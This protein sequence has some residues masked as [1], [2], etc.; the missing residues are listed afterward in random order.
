MQDESPV[1]TEDDIDALNRRAVTR[2]IDTTRVASTV[3]LVVG[4]LLALAW[5]WEVLRTQ[6][7]IADRGNEGFS[8]LY[9][10]ENLTIKQRV[11]ALTTTIT[12]LAFAS[13]VAGFGIWLRVYCAVAALRVGGSLTGWEVGDRIDETDEAEPI[14][15]DPC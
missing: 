3:L 4:T 11:D 14:A 6:G 1:I 15:L 7:L 2:V 10:G 13:L 5:I 9:L 8:I 12:L